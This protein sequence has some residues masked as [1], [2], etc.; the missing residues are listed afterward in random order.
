MTV[1]HALRIARR[2]RCVAEAARR[3]LVEILPLVVVADLVDEILIR[4]EMLELDPGQMVPVAKRDELLHTPQLWC[5]LEYEVGKGRIEKECAVFRVIDD[6]DELLG[7]EPRVERVIDAARA[8][9]PVPGLDMAGSI[10]RQRA[11]PV[12]RPDAKPIE[13]LGATPRAPRDLAI[14]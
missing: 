2:A 11:D 1:E 13:C 6:V 10:P 5:D 8:R 14:S 7:E 9:D 3:V 4:R 12:A